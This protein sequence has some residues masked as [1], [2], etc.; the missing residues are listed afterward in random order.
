MLRWLV[1]SALVLVGLTPALGVLRGLPAVH[2]NCD[3]DSACHE[4][5]VQVSCCGERIETAYCLRSEG[6]CRC[7]TAPKREPAKPTPA[8]RPAPERDQITAVPSQRTVEVRIA[9]PERATRSLEPCGISL[10][11]RLGHNGVQALIGVWRT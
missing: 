7:V 5:V 3:G 2:G 4:I 11:E 6:P 1:I 9:E 8:P 10:V